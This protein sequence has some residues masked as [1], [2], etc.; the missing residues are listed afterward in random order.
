MRQTYEV[1]PILDVNKT[2]IV[3]QVTAFLVYKVNIIVILTKYYE[4]NS[5]FGF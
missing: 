3:T 2:T 4:K 5:P 1:K